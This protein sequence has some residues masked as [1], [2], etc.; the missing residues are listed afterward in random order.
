VA[1]H[2]LFADFSHNHRLLRLSSLSLL[3]VLHL[4]F[5]SP[6]L[7]AFFFFLHFYRFVCLRTLFVG[8]CCCR[9]RPLSLFLCLYG[10]LPILVVE[11]TTAEAKRKKKREERG[12]ALQLLLRSSLAVLLGSLHRLQSLGA[13]FCRSSL[14]L[15]FFFFFFSDLRRAKH[16]RSDVTHF[17]FSVL[18]LLL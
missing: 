8:C 11:L 18:Y 6:V 4:L 2:L 13:R 16:A 7:Y 12:Y 3:F 5:C 9:F 15:P 1:F 17:F 14:L 10:S